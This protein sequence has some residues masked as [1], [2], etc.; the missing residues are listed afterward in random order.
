VVRGVD[1]WMATVDVLDDT[2]RWTRPRS[3]FLMPDAMQSSVMVTALARA[4]GVPSI[5]TV[6]ASVAG[7][8]RAL[9]TYRADFV[10]CY[11]TECVDAFREIGW[12]ASRIVLT[13]APAMDAARRASRERD[14]ADAVRL[15]GLDGSLPIVVVATSRPS[16]AEDRW[17]SRLVDAGRARG[18]Q[19]VVKPHPLHGARAYADVRGSGGDGL[20]VLE[21]IDLRMLLNASDVV[22]TDYSHAGREALACERPLVAVNTTGMPYPNNRYDEEGVALAAKTDDEVA[23]VVDRALTDDAARE[24]MAAARRVVADRFNWKND[25]RAARRFYELLA[26]PPVRRASRVR[27]ADVGNP[28]K[29]P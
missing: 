11:G 17:I 16:A 18:W 23:A 13:G 19:I 21:A 12:D 25:G 4:H 14:R 8:A 27:S 1:E 9:G 10:A 3:V 24:A 2:L 26:D 22:V 28:I 5:T 6:A 29:A 15:G 7:T 20:R